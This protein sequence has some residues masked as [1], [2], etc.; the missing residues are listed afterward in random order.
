VWTAYFVYDYENNSESILI[1]EVKR[2][3]S[4]I[5]SLWT[6]SL[7]SFSSYVGSLVETAILILV[8]NGTLFGH[9]AVVSANN[10]QTL[11]GS[12][13][14]TDCERTVKNLVSKINNIISNWRIRVIIQYGWN[15]IN[16]QDKSLRVSISINKMMN[17]NYYIS[18]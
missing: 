2:P 9:W 11:Q 14:R 5:K 4:N 8:K 10:T 15:C 18:W 12:I 7:K 16:P 3:L 13:L 6:A 1:R 17:E